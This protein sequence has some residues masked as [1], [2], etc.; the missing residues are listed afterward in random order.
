[1]NRLSIVILS[2]LCLPLS[3]F[4]Q[5]AQREELQFLVIEALTRNPE[6]AAATIQ[7]RVAERRI[8]QASALDDPQLIFKLMEIPGTNFNQATYANVELMQMIRFPTKLSKQR[9]IAVVQAEH[10]HHDHIEKELEIVARLKSIYAMLQ[11]ARAALVL[12]QENQ[13]L[14]EQ[15]QSVA[16]T[17]YSVGKASQQEVLKASVELAKL[18]AEEASLQQEV[19]TAESMMKALLNRPATAPIGE[20]EILPVE[21]LRQPLDT[22][23][24]YAAVNRPMLIH[25]SLTVVESGLNLDLMQQEYLPDLKFSVEYVRMPVVMENR[26]S[27]NAGITIPFAP[28]TLSKASSRVEEAEAQ[29]LVQQSNLQWS[30][31]MVDALIREAYAKVKAAEFEVNTYEKTI[32]PQ[33]E[34]S[35]R[36][37]LTEYQTGKTAFIMLLDSYRMLRMSKTDAAMARMKHTRALATLERNVG[38]ADIN[39]ISSSQE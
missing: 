19:I 27:F 36:A 26:W 33:S 37:Q 35:V 15:I 34:Q 18:R 12:N 16:T 28:W 23:L 13:K 17:Q 29:T 5:E 3:V 8:P 9:D 2:A 30:R 7:M 11:Y 6:V 10:A 14:L 1:M 22:L 4:G 38:V 20:L 32:L 39:V 21:P 25:D 31:R 24:H